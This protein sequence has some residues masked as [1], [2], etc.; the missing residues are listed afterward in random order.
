MDAHL[1]QAQR[2]LAAVCFPRGDPVGVLLL[3]TRFL[4]RETVLL[5]L[6]ALQLIDALAQDAQSE[7][8][9]RPPGVDAAHQLPGFAGIGEGEGRRRVRAIEIHREA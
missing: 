4:L 1:G 2:H 7:L 9:K 3:V 5:A 6:Q 8:R